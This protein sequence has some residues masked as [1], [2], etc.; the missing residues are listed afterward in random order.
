MQT[1][2]E[3]RNKLALADM[4]AWP[5]LLDSWRA[6][7]EGEMAKKNA[8]ALANVRKLEQDEI[9]KRIEGIRPGNNR[10]VREVLALLNNEIKLLKGVKNG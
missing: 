9:D 1:T 2:L 4:P 5:K 7:I 3:M 10:A 8:A 6:E